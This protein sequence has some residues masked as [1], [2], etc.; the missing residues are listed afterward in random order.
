MDDNEEDGKP[1]GQHKW[2]S[3]FKALFHQ[4]IIVIMIIVFSEISNSSSIPSRGKV[5]RYRCNIFNA[6]R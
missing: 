6:L 2:N 1:D 4:Y 5:S 3:T